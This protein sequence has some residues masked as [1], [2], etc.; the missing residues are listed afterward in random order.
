MVER[1]AP[2]QGVLY[3]GLMIT[4]EGPKLIEYNVRFGD[5]ECQVLMLRLESDLLPLLDAAARGDL[6]HCQVNWSEDTALT[7]V[8]AAKGY[9]GGHRKGTIIRGLPEAETVEGVTV[10]HAGTA[11]SADGEVIA[12]GGRVLDVSATGRNTEEARSRAYRAIS[13]ID[14]PEGFFRKD[15]GWRSLDREKIS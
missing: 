8:M 11:R 9:P 13:K 15:I 14:W 3:A 5:P 6:S 2:F 1:G 10:F 4:S 12:Q 7:V